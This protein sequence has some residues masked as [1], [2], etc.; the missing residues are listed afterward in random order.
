[1]FFSVSLSTEKEEANGFRWITFPFFPCQES[2]EESPSLFFLAVFHRSTT[3]LYLLSS[4]KPLL[5]KGDRNSLATTPC[6][7]LRSLSSLVHGDWF[8][9][10]EVFRQVE[11]QRFQVSRFPHPGF[12][13]GF[14]LDSH[15]PIPYKYLRMTVERHG[16]LPFSNSVFLRNEDCDGA[17]RAFAQERMFIFEI[18]PNKEHISILHSA[19]W[20]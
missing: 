19:I 12:F 15:N 16:P 6:P 10:L 11:L 14:K 2:I 7:G 3:W 13:L 5:C 4:D 17:A 18:N 8:R 9:K 20:E 1:M